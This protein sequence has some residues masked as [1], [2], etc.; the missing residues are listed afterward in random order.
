MNLEQLGWSDR[1]ACSFRSY[2]DQG[3][4]VGRVAVEHRNSYLLYTEQG[5]QLAAVSGKLRHQTTGIQDF[6]AV[7]DWVVIQS[8]SIDHRA[9]IH[10]ILPRKSKF[11]RNVAGSTTEEQVIAANVDTVFLVSG[12]DGD[13][14][15]RR[16]E[17]YLI[18][19]WESG[20][21]PVIVLNKVDLCLHV[22]RRLAEIEAIA[23]G[24]P[25]IALSAT[26]KQGMDALQSYLQAGKTIALLGSSGVG[27]S[28]I[29]NQLNSEP[30][31]TV[32][33]VRRRDDRGRHTTTHRQLILLPSGALM[34]DTPGMREIQVWSG[35]EGL[36]ETFP[37]IETLAQQCHFRDCQ[38]QQE[39]GCAI[40]QA[41]ADGHLDQGRFLNYQK[42]QREL[43]YLARKQDQRATLAEKERWKKI[44]KSL[45]NHPKYRE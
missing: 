8:S 35:A 40:Q 16:I 6:P 2:Y 20:A 42:L 4:A 5:E 3:F 45:R 25:V 34:I 12:L 44:H 31:Q 14:N 38:H 41:L 29:A 26:Q 30:L 43:Y 11:S 9:T 27:K 24:V 23:I 21:S 32:Q 28:T 13:L 10:A 19:A 36:T 37:E 15:P 7:G 18:L 17:R 22:E 33:A 1:Y 39:P